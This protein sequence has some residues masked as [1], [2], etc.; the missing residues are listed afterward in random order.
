MQ[1]LPTPEVLV[2]IQPSA[3]FH[4][5]LLRKYKNEEKDARID[6]FLASVALSR[7]ETRFEEKII[8]AVQN[9]S[10]KNI[11]KGTGS[12]LLFWSSRL[13]KETQFE[14]S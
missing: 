13:W 6:L 9:K 10:R 11:F 14:R 1:S 5:E 4:K 2:R 8:F 7:S 3:I 12:L